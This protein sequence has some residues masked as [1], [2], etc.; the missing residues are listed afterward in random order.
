MV[1]KEEDDERTRDT[2]WGDRDIDTPES[3]LKNVEHQIEDEVKEIEHEVQKIEENLERE[4]EEQD[5][6]DGSLLELLN[7]LGPIKDPLALVVLST[8][9][10]EFVHEY[11]PEDFP[12]ISTW[13]HYDLNLFSNLPYSPDNPLAKLFG[14]PKIKTADGH[15]KNDYEVKGDIPGATSSESPKEL[16]VFVHGW[17]ASEKSALGR[18]S[19]LRY[20]MRK[21]GYEHPVV[22]FT[23]P[24]NQPF[25]EWKTAKSLGKRN[26]IKLAQF[27]YDYKKHNPN[28][29]IRYISNS[30]G[31]NPTFSAMKQFANADLSDVLESVSVMGGTVK[32]S[33]LNEGGL[34]HDAVEQATD[35]LHNYRSNS[36]HTINTYYKITEF[37]DA[38][39][40][41]APKTPPENFNDHVVD[42]PDHFSF[43]LPER[44]CLDEVVWDFGWDEMM[45][46]RRIEE[47]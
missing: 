23:W 6:I 44:G 43:Y 8:K 1:K 16:L 29:K 46:E 40:A 18:M 38:I 33:K 9:I 4:L 42:V 34:Y 19:T 22:G 25:T 26:G 12:R 32:S 10:E 15:T 39:G 31:A 3:F 28:T 21:N 27:T 17:M 35:V 37:R 24:T 20:V 14:K 36:D 11:Q 41:K 7:I 13:G 5:V 30:L 2:L 45:K 47:T